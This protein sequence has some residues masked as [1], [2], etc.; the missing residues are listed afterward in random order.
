M[1]ELI[2]EYGHTLIAL[3]I[4]TAML[5]GLT[6]GTILPQ[7][8]AYFSAT[9]PQDTPENAWNI[10]AFR[11]NFN[12]PFPVITTETTFE[13]ES[14]TNV[15]FDDLLANKKIVAINAD[16]ADVSEGIKVAPADTQTKKFF[17]AELGTFGGPNLVPGEYIF[18]LSV[19]DHTD[20]E[21]FG[22]T[23]QQYFKIVVVDSSL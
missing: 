20:S 13:M 17:D 19:V 23:T 14:G 8:G 10:G 11:N 6:L 15:D 5:V 22:K 1:R 3:I 21:H 4:T 7:M 2:E 16:G 9:L 18:I 12:R